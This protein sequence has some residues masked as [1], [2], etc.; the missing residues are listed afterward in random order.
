[1]SLISLLVTLLVVAILIYVGKLIMDMLA[2]P[3]RIQQLIGLIVLII[4]AVWLLGVLGVV[5]P[6]GNIRIG[7]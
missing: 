7:G 4:L 1:M 5:G 6:V 3:A 2:I